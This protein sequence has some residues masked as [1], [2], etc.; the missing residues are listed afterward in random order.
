METEAEEGEMNAHGHS[1]NETWRQEEKNPG[2][3][4]S[5]SPASTAHSN[6]GKP[7]CI[8]VFLQVLGWALL[9]ITTGLRRS[10]TDHVILSSV[11]SRLIYNHSPFK[12][13]GF[14]FILFDHF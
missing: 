4:Q 10:E 5:G 3:L 2:F 13:R 9:G 12:P 14:S 7:Q 1:G 6:E 11:H 8:P